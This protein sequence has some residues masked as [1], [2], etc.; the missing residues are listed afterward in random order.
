MWD[1]EPL[2]R[3]RFIPFID[4]FQLT[5]RANT[6]RLVT[7]E[8]NSEDAVWAKDTYGLEMDYYFFHG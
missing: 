4:Q 8:Y 6:I 3:N 7:S 5:Y 2:H 1:Q